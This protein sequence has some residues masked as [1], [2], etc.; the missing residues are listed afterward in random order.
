MLWLTKLHPKSKVGTFQRLYPA[1]S[2]NSIH[3]EEYCEGRKMLT[4]HELPEIN[5]TI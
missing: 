5:Q 3:L 2:I 1:C 4:T